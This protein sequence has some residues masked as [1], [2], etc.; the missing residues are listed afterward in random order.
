GTFLAWEIRQK[1]AEGDDPWD[2]LDRMFQDPKD[3]LSL[4]LSKSVSKT[5]QKLWASLDKSERRLLQ[6]ISRLDLTPDQA[7]LVYAT[8]TG[9]SATLVGT[10]DEILE[11]PYRIYEG[12]RLSADPISFEVIDL[13][14]TQ[15]L[16]L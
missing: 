12:S 11:N 5:H 8:A 6:L 15:S 16:N 2:Q 1:T 9:D 7:E 10:A 3:I 14:M 13:G 4:E